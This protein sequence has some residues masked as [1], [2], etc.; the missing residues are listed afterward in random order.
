MPEPLEPSDL[1]VSYIDRLVAYAQSRMADKQLAADAVQEALT[2]A[3][4]ASAQLQDSEKLLPWLYTILR[5]TMADMARKQGREVTMDTLP[6]TAEP[7]PAEKSEICQCF[8]PLLGSLP[9]D[10]G[11]VIQQID[12]DEQPREVVAEHFG[13]SLNNLTVKLH[14]ARQKLREALEKTCDMCAH[15]GCL[16]CTCGNK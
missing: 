16:N 8:K 10:Y 14:R 12:L 4:R 15:H 13:I 7:E 5:N 6:E 9:S 3:V 2:K 11:S 1:I